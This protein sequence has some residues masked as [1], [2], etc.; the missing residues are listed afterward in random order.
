MTVDQIVQNER[1][2]LD[3]FCREAQA[4]IIEAL[5]GLTADGWDERARVAEI[6]LDAVRRYIGDPDAIRRLAESEGDEA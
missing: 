2:E 6:N 4:V 3:G 1:A 5:S